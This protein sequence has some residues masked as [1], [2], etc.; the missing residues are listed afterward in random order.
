L[1]F[2]GLDLLEMLGFPMISTIHHVSKT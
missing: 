1:K 2:N